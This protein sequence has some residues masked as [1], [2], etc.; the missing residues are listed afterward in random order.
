MSGTELDPKGGE[1]G[2][3]ETILTVSNAFCDGKC[4]HWCPVPG[5]PSLV[6]RFHST[7]RPLPGEYNSTILL[8]ERRAQRAGKKGRFALNAQLLYREISARK[9]DNALS[10]PLSVSVSPRGG[11]GPTPVDATAAEGAKRKKS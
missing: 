9:L 11:D 1:G 2:E 3:R 5:W 10:H 7:P 6:A 4:F 8:G